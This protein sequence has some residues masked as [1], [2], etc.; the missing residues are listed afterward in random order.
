MIR[1]ETFKASPAEDTKYKQLYKKYSLGSLDLT[2]ANDLIQSNDQVAIEI[3]GQSYTFILGA[4]DLRPPQYKLRTQSKQGATDLPR[5]ANKTFAGKTL[6]GEYDVRITSDARFFSA[7]IIQ[8][9]DVLYIEPARKTIP[10]AEEST[11]VIYW[12][13]D[14]IKDGKEGSCGVDEAHT[15]HQDDEEISQQEGGDRS[16]SSICK[17]IKIAIANDYLMFERYGSVEAVETHNLSVLNQ[18]R[19]KFDDEFAFEYYHKLVEI[20]VVTD[21]LGDP[22]SPSTSSDTLLNQFSS[23]AP[24]GFENYHNVASLWTARVF[25]E[26]VLGLAWVGGI[27]I[28]TKRYN[29]N[30]DFSTNLASLVALQAHELGH[31]YGAGHS[32]PGYIMNSSM[33]D[34]PPTTWATSSI[35][36]INNRLAMVY[37]LQGCQADG[38]SVGIGTYYPD[39]SAALDITSITQGMLVPRMTTARRNGIYLPAEGLLVF[40][41]TSSSFWYR[42]SNSW[43]ELVDSV[44]SEVKRSGPNSIYMGLTDN[45]GIGTETPQ[46]K[47]Q[48][49]TP[50]EMTGISHTNGTVEVATWTSGTSGEFG[51]RSNHPFRL[52]ANSGIDQFVLMPNG[53]VGL[54]TSFSDYPLSFPSLIGDKISFYGPQAGPH[55]GI[56]IAPGLLQIHVDGP[57]SDIVFGRGSSAEFTEWMRMK[58][59]GAVGIATSTPDKLFSIANKLGIDMQG[60]IHS[61]NS[62]AHMMHMFEGT[63]SANKMV[64][65]HSAQYPD[66]GM[67]YDGNSNKFRFLADSNQVMAIELNTNSVVVNG[68]L[69]IGYTR[70]V[71]AWVNISPGSF[72]VATCDCPAGTIVMGGGYNKDETGGNV[73]DLEI[74]DNSAVSDEQWSVGVNNKNLFVTLK[75]RASAI[76]ARLEH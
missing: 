31:N 74:R 70:V 59:T 23:W 68:S 14:R 32:G 21:P 27:C 66:W 43:V 49:Q 19:L 30:Q 2:E 8:A 33:T 65:S 48:V 36:E 40:D 29:V 64:I 6:E 38:Q 60:T 9:A 50:A 4:N 52:F 7:M 63:S 54:N 57:F 1:F 76:C 45:V 3:D 11:M 41:K 18:V 44:S 69:K 62:V 73:G 53:Y 37:C 58:G 34:P 25:D 12:D 22:W 17:D 26:G 75:A 51:T 42:N 72:G 39:P 35:N 28:S 61:K 56:G 71:G 16:T 55:Y 20:F 67:Q 47:L 24:T 46:A 13:S 10:A 5:T 15:I